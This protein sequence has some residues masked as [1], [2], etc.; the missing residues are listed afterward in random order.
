[1]KKN[2]FTKYKE[3]K[4]YDECIEEPLKELIFQL[5]NNGFNTESSCGHEMYVQCQYILDG[6]LMKLHNLLYNYC[7]NNQIQKTYDIELSIHVCEGH[8]NPTLI[9][10]FPS[11]ADR[12]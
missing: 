6:E 1:M 9:I 12:K 11:K 8:L 7:D 10:K 3:F 4:W 5:R 2:S